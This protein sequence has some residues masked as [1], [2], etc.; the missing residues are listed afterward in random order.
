MSALLLTLFFTTIFIPNLSSFYP[1]STP[2]QKLAEGAPNVVLVLTLSYSSFFIL[3][4]S[5]LCLIN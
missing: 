2:A 5:S 4:L 1:A 3:A